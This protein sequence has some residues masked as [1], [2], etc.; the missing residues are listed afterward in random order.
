MIIIIII[1]SIHKQQSFTDHRQ[2]KK[3]HGWCSSESMFIFTESGQHLLFLFPPLSGVLFQLHKW[4]I[5]QR[6]KHCSVQ[7]TLFI[8]ISCVDWSVLF[9]YLCKRK[10][11]FY[12]ATQKQYDNLTWI[13]F[14]TEPQIGQMSLFRTCFFGKKVK[15][16]R[17]LYGKERTNE[18]SHWPGSNLDHPHKHHS[19]M[20]QERSHQPLHSNP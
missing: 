17:K 6:H 1:V 12:G 15:W 14:E 5:S 16:Y 20:C 7:K 18:K 4:P 13:C 11:P 10:H 8:I 9:Q 19:S 2:I 3:N